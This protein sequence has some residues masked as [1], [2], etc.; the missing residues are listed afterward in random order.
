[1]V[2]NFP[3]TAYR[4]LGYCGYLNWEEWQASTGLP[5]IEL[6]LCAE[7]RKSINTYGKWASEHGLSIMYTKLSAVG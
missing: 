2:K 3:V 6:L 4:G 1:M 7:Q 5:V